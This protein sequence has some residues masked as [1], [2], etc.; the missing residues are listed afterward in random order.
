MEQIFNEKLDKHEIILKK[1]KKDAITIG[2][3]K[4]ILFISI[5][6][7]L[8]FGLNDGVLFIFSLLET[9]V[10]AFIWV[11]HHKLK[12]KIHYIKTMIDI[13]SR[14]QKRI[15]GEW[16]TFID[17]GKEF[18]DE[19][20]PYAADLDIVGKESLFQYLNTTHTFYGRKLLAQSLLEPN[21][22]I[23]EITLKQKGVQELSN[24]L[25]L[26]LDMENHFSN[27]G[28][29][30]KTP[31]LIEDLKDKTLFISNKTLLLFLKFLPI[32]I[33]IFLIFMF[34]FQNTILI[35]MGAGILLILIASWLFGFTINQKYL[36]KLSY[37]PYTLSEYNQIIIKI[38]QLSFTSQKLNDIKTLLGKTVAL[39]AFKELNIIT[40]MSKVNKNA[41]FSFVLN[42]LFQWDYRI[43]IMYQNWKI[44][45]AN[46]AENWFIA[47][48]EFE[49]LLN[50]AIYPHLNSKA[51]M[52]VFNDKLEINVKEI[53]HPLINLK[54]RVNN[55]F[56]FNNEIF[57]ISGSNM[58]GKTTFLRTLGINIILGK[59]GSFVC[60]DKMESGIFNIITS[61]RIK[62][63]LNEGVSTFYGELKRIKAILD[64]AK[65]DKSCLFLID[66]IFKGTNSVDRLI[67]AQ[68]VIDKLNNANV[69]G[70]LTTHDLE[71]CEIA[72]K[73]KRIKNASFAEYY[74]NNE[75]HFDYKIK[76]G[77]STTTNA[78]YL[79]EM[80]EII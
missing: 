1:E 47:L 14:H 70:L 75:I 60:A 66:E 79:M 67:G 32:P 19:N 56:K 5:I 11:I 16:T 40:G 46:E 57:I 17:I 6:V 64:Y 42:V 35:S 7:S 20:H 55:N 78:K 77:K 68:N 80:L 9:A 38:Q 45:Y 65:K 52:P 4:L 10:F 37:L 27:I 31:K 43:S 23:E 73:N 53:G 30:S 59:A 72:S 2:Y 54:T 34:I 69:C 29:D 28:V 21:T 13:I 18:I 63:N 71:L 74:E 24:D 48:G 58:S 44:K 76:E 41:I 12:N 26:L 61:M 39:K 25:D 50:L 3:L 22:T 36:A 51:S 62:D 33:F 8:Y 15:N 49:Y